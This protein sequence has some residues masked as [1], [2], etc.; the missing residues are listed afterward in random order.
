MPILYSDWGL[1]F[2]RVWQTNGLLWE[3]PKN[4]KK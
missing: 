2:E 3:V 4:N 1:S